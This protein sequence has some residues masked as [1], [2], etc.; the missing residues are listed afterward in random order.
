MHGVSTGHPLP[1]HPAFAFF[2]VGYKNPNNTDNKAKSHSLPF[3]SFLTCC[4]LLCALSSLIRL[5]VG[6]LLD[7]N[8]S[9]LCTS[10]YSQR[11]NDGTASGKIG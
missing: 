10:V 11:T 5:V 4:Q 9:I 1:I 6:T 3:M 7:K 8:S 2:A